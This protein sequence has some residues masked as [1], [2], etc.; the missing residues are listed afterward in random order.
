M[1]YAL[2]GAGALGLVIGA[3]LA[4]LLGRASYRHELTQVPRLPLHARW[5]C[6]PILGIIFSLLARQPG[7]LTP[8]AACFAVGGCWLAWV[9]VDVHR[10]PTPAVLLTGAGTLLAVCGAAA[11][12]SSW[13]PLVG[14]ALGAVLLGCFYGL[15]SLAGLGD[16]DVHLGAVAGLLLGAHGLLEVAQ[17][18]F[19]T[20]AVG[21]MVAVVALIG[22]R[23]RASRIAFG[24]AIIVGALATLV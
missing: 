16:G 13:E 3:G 18:T 23:D 24:P 8:A 12:K 5:L 1:T 6:A 11:A 14:A 20:F 10:L 2:A 22:G 15:L 17:A 19:V 9:D 4:V 7:P 21:A